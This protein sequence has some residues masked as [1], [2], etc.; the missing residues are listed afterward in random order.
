[1]AICVKSEIGP[2]KKVLLHRPGQELEHLVPEELERLLFDDIPY[3]KLAQQEHDT[4]A[5][6]LRRQGV[7]V[8]YLEDLMAETLRLNPG[9]RELFVGQFLREGGPFAQ[10]HAE[11]LFDMLTS[12]EDERELVLK[13]MSGVSTAEMRDELRAGPL[14]RLTR[15]RRQFLLDP[16]PN[17]YFTRDPFA[18]IG[19]GV[20]LHRM[21]SATRC[22]ETIYAEFILRY[23]PDFAGQVP[24]YYDRSDPF[25]IE[26]GDILNLREDLLAI[27]LSQRTSP[28][29]VEL[30]ARRLFADERCGVRRIL[31]LDI[32]NMRAYMHLDTV[33][34]QVD[35]D[36]FTIHPDILGSLRLY[37]LRRDGT[38][39]RA[40]EL[41]SPLE[42]VLRE[43]LGLERVTLIACG[44]KD[45]IASARE[46]WND[47]SNTLCIAP[48]KVIVYNRN[49]VTNEILLRHGLEV[50]EMPSSEL[51][52]GRGGP[53]CMSMPLVRDAL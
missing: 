45:N 51:A 13:T 14:T 16:I 22:R 34:T 49:Y 26:G 40:S 29:A 36:K 48:G 35:R 21:Y 20:S 9:L 15:E 42:D 47:G 10:N 46:Q 43:A 8:V 38:A 3:L 19:C 17:L 11:E 12:L 31:V 39:M 2:L 1:M 37:E 27:G 41:S 7:E 53:R 4:F 33:F 44:G 24:F 30:L 18:S 52:R 28:E 6:I 5:A 32:P 23:H 25:H 50:F